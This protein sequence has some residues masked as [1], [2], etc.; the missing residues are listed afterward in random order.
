MSAAE[1]NTPDAGM[2]D[3]VL[4]SEGLTA[5]G[6]LV[7][8]KCDGREVSFAQIPVTNDRI[9]ANQGLFSHRIM[10]LYC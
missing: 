9:H 5:T 3:I 7:S 1:Q 4:G 10:L 8:G 2:A 6:H